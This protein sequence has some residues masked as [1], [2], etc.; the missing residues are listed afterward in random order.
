MEI[1]R[2]G[3]R[4]AELIDTSAPRRDIH[5]NWQARKR[6]EKGRKRK[7]YTVVCAHELASRIGARVCSYRAWFSGVLGDPVNTEPRE[8]EEEGRNALGSHARAIA[9]WLI[10]FRPYFY[11]SD[12][13]SL[14]LQKQKE[15]KERK[16]WKLRTDASNGWG[17]RECPPV[18]WNYLRK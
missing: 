10:P 13:L 9:T 2:D 7:R 15:G 3:R 8:K 12:S 17:H 18:E 1:S 16:R 14:V 6:G 4:V 5:T 11:P